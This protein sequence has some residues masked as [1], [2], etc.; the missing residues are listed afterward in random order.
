MFSIQVISV[1]RFDVLKKFWHNL[2]LCRS[3]GSKDYVSETRHCDK[4]AHVLDKL[5]VTCKILGF[6]KTVFVPIELSKFNDVGILYSPII[7]SSIN[8]V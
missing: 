5:G 3:Q 7:R 1:A 8:F 2:I 4:H 6:R